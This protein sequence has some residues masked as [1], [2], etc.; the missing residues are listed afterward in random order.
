[1]NK[2]FLEFA[3]E[4]YKKVEAATQNFQK[5]IQPFAV[6]QRKNMEAAIENLR[7]SSTHFV[8]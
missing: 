2:A 5:A 3:E 4:N 8:N 7:K 1:M 6:T